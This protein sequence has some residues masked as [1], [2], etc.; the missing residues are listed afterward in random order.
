M[1]RRLGPCMRGSWTHPGTPLPA[2]RSGKEVASH[3]YMRLY[4]ATHYS[5]SS[6]TPMISTNKRKGV[7]VVKHIAKGTLIDSSGLRTL[8]ASS[9]ISG[10]VNAPG[11]STI[12]QR[13]IMPAAL[14]QAAKNDKNQAD[15]RPHLPYREAAAEICRDSG[16][17]QAMVGLWLPV[18]SPRIEMDLAMP[19]KSGRGHPIG[20]EVPL[21]R[22]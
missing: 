12:T 3:H 10:I 5:P 9:F 22:R 14:A 19:S 11:Y 20:F 16:E 17:P 4:A 18:H 13:A 8:S 21:A 15:G 7:W 2:C 1:A 6:T